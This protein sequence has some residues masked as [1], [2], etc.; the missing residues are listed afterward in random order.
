VT[1]LKQAAAAMKELYD[2][3]ALAER[4]AGHQVRHRTLEDRLLRWEV[5]KAK[6][7]P[8]NLRKG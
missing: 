2:G 3:D 1:D 6:G 8:E 5:F 7:T 4:R